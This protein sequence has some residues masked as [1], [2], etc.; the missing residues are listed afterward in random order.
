MKKNVLKKRILT[1]IIVLL[2]I[3]LTVAFFAY[4][5]IPD[6]EKASETKHTVKFVTYN[7]QVIE[8]KVVTSGSTVEAP[9]V[10]MVKS[11]YSFKG[12]YDGAKKW[13]FST[14]KVTKD[15]TL[16]AKWDMYLSFAEAKD[17]SDGVWVTGCDFDVAHVEIP[18]EYNGKKVTGIEWGFTHRKLLKTVIL[19]DTITYIGP[20][21]FNRCELLETIVIPQ[22]VQI[23]EENAFCLCTNLKKIYCEATE[24]PS[25]WDANF[26]PVNAEIVLG[27]IPEKK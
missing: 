21:S 16:T 6:E 13:D 5:Y 20:N 23:I 26:N 14:D 8:N 17:G 22:G 10:T 24:I 3:A 9:K 19:P 4:T 27:Y 18:R 1:A 11:G 7:D 15:T 2:V 25:G 12:W